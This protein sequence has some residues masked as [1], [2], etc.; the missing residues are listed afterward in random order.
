MKKRPVRFLYLVLAFLITLGSGGYAVVTAQT[1]EASPVASPDAT[2]LAEVLPGIQMENLD[3]SVD[4]GDDFYRFA[5]GG[6]LDRT[7]LPGSSPAY[8]TF[9]ELND[10]VTAE[11]QEIVLGLEAD[12]STDTGKV[13]VVYDQF[14][15]EDE[16]NANGIEPIQP[17]LEEIAEIDS[18]EAGLLFQQQAQLDELGLFY[19]F[20]SSA[21]DDATSNIGWF[22]PA[23]LNL[24]DREYYLD[25]SEEGEAIR[26][27]WVDSTT[28][29][30]VIL[31]YTE[32]DAA[33]AA[34]QVLAFETELAT[35][36][37]PS[38]AYNDP[39]TYNNPR[40]IEEL[41][42]LI[43]GFDWAAWFDTLGVT[44][45]G[46]VN[47]IDITWLEGFAAV[48]EGADPDTLRNYFTAQLIWDNSAYLS[49]D[50]ADISFAF[51]SGVLLGVTER[52][53]IEERGIFAVQ[54]LFPDAL[55]QAYV[56][57]AFPP[58]SKAAIEDLVAN[59][60][61]AFGERIRNATWMTEETKL[62]AL[63]KLELMSVKVGYPDTWKSY[64]DVETGDSLFGSVHSAHQL[65]TQQDLAKIGQPVDRTEWGMA[66]FEVN[67]YYN[68]SLNE[69]V[70]PAA[71]LQAPFFD[72]EADLASNY[73]AIGSVIGHEI[74][75]GFDASG[76][77]F[78]GYGNISQWWT[79]EDAAAFDALNEEVVVQYSELE[80]LPGLNVD[81]G[82][83]VTENVA[84]MGGIQAAYDAL[85]VA[86]GEPVDEN[87]PWFLTQQ[88]RFFI[89]A[90]STWRQKATDEYVQ[91]L[92]SVDVH[93]PAEARAT[94]PLKNSDAFYEAFD[95]VEGDP[96][97]LAPDD[98]I[99]I[100]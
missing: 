78:D 49:I 4:P 45:P 23:A 34:E 52:R 43:P 93:A 19:L 21:L 29:L 74:T 31:G 73:G 57:V 33:A 92:V 69:I 70:F 64:A 96:E 63:E 18:I 97:Y 72:A 37:T 83:T 98:R 22:G 60:I 15:D 54:D 36:T 51:A 61:T 1:P 12:P 42:T 38:E 24:P 35:I 94:Q 85:L 77:N 3:L 2:P 79:E 89:A 11:L 53:P 68:A 39:A 90:S 8:G 76:S 13:K 87:L 82:L 46:S 27:A 25:E 17:I 7:E 99:V 14:T 67:A 84:D 86:L 95:I 75:H 20:A 88:Q 16:R 59:L 50:I 56:D 44:D 40:T 48:L 91:Y 66:A 26:Q 32:A 58:E 65:S 62:K 41:E 28:Q 47:V 55:S 30:F 100:W 5:N 10:K 81:G 71:I 6:W 9:D 80:V